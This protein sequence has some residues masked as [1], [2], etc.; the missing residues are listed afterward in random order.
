MNP[1]RW[2]AA[3]SAI[4]C[5]VFAAVWV[6]LGAATTLFMAVLLAVVGS[7]L[8]DSV[9]ALALA[10]PTVLYTVALI[11]Y[12]LYLAVGPRYRIPAS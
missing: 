3:R 4:A 5:A 9:N 12:T 10:V 2:G 11:G 6:W 8:G 1:A 7:A